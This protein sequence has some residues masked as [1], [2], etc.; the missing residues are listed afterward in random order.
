MKR[1]NKRLTSHYLESME[2]T[3][4]GYGW[5]GERYRPRETESSVI[6]DQAREMD[7]LTNE[8]QI[9]DLELARVNDENHQYKVQ[10]EAMKS[11]LNQA[12]T[13]VKSENIPHYDIRKSHDLSRKIA[14]LE[15]YINEQRDLISNPHHSG[16]D[17]SYKPVF[18]SKLTPD[19]PTRNIPQD[20]CL[21]SAPPLRDLY[22][23]SANPRL[24]RKH[25]GLVDTPGQE[26]TRVRSFYC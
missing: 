17:L 6:A 18:T 21:R 20:P 2:S 16:Y 13:L 11:Q 9:R 15:T 5:E 8:L 10:F 22:S 25:E 23:N 14:A 3:E 24:L 26:L 7:R 1:E 4:Y 12:L 19:H